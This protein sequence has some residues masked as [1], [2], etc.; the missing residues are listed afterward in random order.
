MKRKLF[1]T[2]ALL[3]C[4]LSLVA[5]SSVV[6]EELKGKTISVS[7]NFADNL[8][9]AQWYVMF[10]RGT[11]P[12]KHGYLYENVEKHTLY[13]TATAPSGTTATAAKYLVRL[14]DAGDGKFYIQTG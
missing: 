8:T 3:T 7:A 11:Q 10:D 12:K 5:Q 4:A 9:A 14:S 1:S 2:V 13:N 6:L